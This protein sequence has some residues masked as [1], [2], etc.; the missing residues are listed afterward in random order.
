LVPLRHASESST[1]VSAALRP[2]APLRTPN[3]T[4]AY[5]ADELLPAFFG[6]PAS[7]VS[8]ASLGNPVLQDYNRIVGGVHL[9]T[10]RARTAA[11]TQTQYA[12][13][14]D[15]RTCSPLGFPLTA[16]TD[17]S[18][19][20]KQHAVLQNDRYWLD[21]ADP[22]ASLQEQVRFL[23]SRA[24]VGRATEDLSVSVATYDSDT[25]VFVLE[26]VHFLFSRSGAVQVRA[27]ARGVEA[28][29]LAD[30]SVAGAGITAAVGVILFA[31]LSLLLHFAT[32]IRGAG[33]PSAAK[34]GLDIL[35]LLAALLYLATLLLASI[36][37]GSMTGLKKKYDL[38]G[39]AR[40]LKIFTQPSTVTPVL[41][42]TWAPKVKLLDDTYANV[43]EAVGYRE[44][45]E[46]AYLFAVVFS[47]LRFV[48]SLAAAPS[49]ARVPNTM[50]RVLW[51]GKG[52][53]FALPAYA[54]IFYSVGSAAQGAL[55]L[56]GPMTL[57]GGMRHMASLALN[58][59]TEA[60][61][62]QSHHSSPHTSFTVTYT[63]PIIAALFAI[64]FFLV[65]SVLA[66]NTLIAMVVNA[67]LQEV[68]DEIEVKVSFF[69]GFVEAYANYFCCCCCGKFGRHQGVEN[70]LMNVIQGKR[71][72][73]DDDDE[74]A[75]AP[76]I[77][78]WTYNVIREQLDKVR[79]GGE[80]GRWGRGERMGANAWGRRGG[81]GR[82]W[83]KA[84]V[85]G[86]VV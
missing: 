65:V 1:A 21:A 4:L 48:F 56:N 41:A 64:V 25:H 15:G 12:E 29:T 44:I 27:G 23:Q 22:L 57:E 47:A 76:P 82:L 38:V 58:M 35:T 55:G 6:A 37:A 75:K 73:G 84:W 69:G 81:G 43:A 36:T 31:A 14:H 86:W 9:R 79:T 5:V 74:K 11:C 16:K 45:A 39:S 70:R 10:T 2:R 3:D 62:F 85:P 46:T 20:D 59:G 71:G 52:L 17:A 19:F 33:L 77:T 32:C 24:W 78:T 68:E 54:V 28:G 30:G 80:R 60:D 50:Q 67:F 13:F 66:L 7:R 40:D 61:L 83:Q 72:Q 51:S 63:A 42:T 18:T 49:T 34:A 26:E 53:L 8:P